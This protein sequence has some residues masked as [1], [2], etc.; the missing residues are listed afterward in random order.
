M[1]NRQL[2]DSCLLIKNP[3]ETK[4]LAW[5]IKITAK[6]AMN[7]EKIYGLIEPLEQKEIRMNLNTALISDIGQ[8]LSTSRLILQTKN[9]NVD[10]EEVEDLTED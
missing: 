7:I 9:T 4:N 3:S 8:F 1:S 2:L 10:A 6:N 5:K